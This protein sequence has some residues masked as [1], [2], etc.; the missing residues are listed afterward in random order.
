VRIADPPHLLA[1]DDAVSAQIVKRA[2]IT[3]DELHERK[4][5]ITLHE[6]EQLFGQLKLAVRAHRSRTVTTGRQPPR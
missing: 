2:T 5:E 4:G 1:G 6:I 3:A